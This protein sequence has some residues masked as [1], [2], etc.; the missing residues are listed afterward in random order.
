[1]ANYRLWR[2]Q[3]EWMRSA[4]RASMLRQCEIIEALRRRDRV[5]LPAFRAFSAKLRE[6]VRRVVP[7][8]ELS[9]QSAE[10]HSLLQ[11]RKRNACAT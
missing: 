3:M 7:A 2:L 5:E 9:F 8:P 1:V 10:I 6:R 4:P 11:N